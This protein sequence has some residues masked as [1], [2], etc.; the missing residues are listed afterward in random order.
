[1]VP[2]TAGRKTSDDGVSVTAGAGG[3]PVPVPER[4]ADCGESGAVS[5]KTRDAVREPSAKGAKL[6]LTVQLAPTA[7]L[8]P[9]VVLL[10]KSAAFVPVIE[11]SEIVMV[12]PV[13]F[14]SVKT[15]GESALVLPTLVELKT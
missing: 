12:E 8:P 9:Q 13:P 5:V 15:K 4:A 2:T 10:L 3:A 6:T 7:R 14:V 1:V 11:M